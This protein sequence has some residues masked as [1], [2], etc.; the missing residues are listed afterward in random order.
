MLQV[1]E[2]LIKLRELYFQRAIQQSK[3]SFLHFIAMF[4]PTLVPDWIMGKHIHVI[5]DKLQ[6]V[7]SG[8]IKR[9]MVYHHVHLNQLYV[10]SYFL[11][12]T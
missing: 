8:E 10:Q 6:K 2:N 1:N 5:A 4:A 12:G 11:H 3:D 7:E 9:L